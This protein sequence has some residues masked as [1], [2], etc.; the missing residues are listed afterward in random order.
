M[1]HTIAKPQMPSA[2]FSCLGSVYAKSI[3]SEVK[4]AIDS[5]LLGSLVPAQIV[6]VID[7]PIPSELSDLIL[8]YDLP[9]FTI[10]TLRR[11]VGL[12]AALREGLR[13]C[14]YEYI[15]RFDTDDISAPNRLHACFDF[16]VRNPSVDVLTTSVYEFRPSNTA[17]VSARTKFVYP[18][19]KQL[20]AFLSRRNTINH[21][22]VVFRKAA[23]LAVGSY[24]H[25]PAFEDYYLWLKCRRSGC[26]FMS[27]EKPLV[28]MRRYATIERRSGLS[29]AIKEYKFFTQSLS[30]NLL[31]L[32]SVFF[33]VVRL[34][35]RL[36]PKS[37]HGF[38]D[39]LPWRS[40]EILIANPD[41]NMQNN[42]I[43]AGLL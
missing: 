5:L 32:H 2:L 13:L 4:A 20:S 30:N 43:Q 1:P 7:G 12:G 22:S 28:Y 39:A 33:F 29:Y 26:V 16:I 15:C 42:L 41:R 35:S 11:N 37:I 6:L 34:V 38:Q 36:L 27:I 17:M 10:V 8:Q 40:G 18:S 19:S 14:H 31:P 3:P 23:I 9:L 21:P 24:E 25:M